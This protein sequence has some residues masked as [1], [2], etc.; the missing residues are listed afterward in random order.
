LLNLW[1]LVVCFV[2]TELLF[3]LSDFQ[4]FLKD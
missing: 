1:C 2:R 3:V 4:R